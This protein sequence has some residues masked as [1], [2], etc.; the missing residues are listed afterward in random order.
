MRKA[1]TKRTLDA[2]KP[3]PADLFVW[4]TEFKGFGCKV[5]PKGKR[6]FILQYQAPGLHRTT[7]RYTLGTYGPMTVDQA[8]KTARAL[9]AQVDTG[10]DPALSK[11]ED[12]R[13]TK[14]DTVD[15]L[16][17]AYIENIRDRLKPRTLELYESLAKLYIRPKLG[18]MPVASITKEDVRRLHSEIAS[19][20]PVTANRVVRLVR[21][22]YS[23]L[24]DNDLFDRANPARKADR[25]KEKS[26][27]RFLTVEEL[28]RL[29]ETLRVAEIVGLPPAPLHTK[30]PSTKRKRN[31]GMFKSELK[32]ANPVAVSVLRFLL[33][34]GWREQEALTLKWSAVDL[35]NGRITLDDTKT[36]KTAHI[37]SAAALELLA[38]QP[39]VKDSPYVFP[40]RNPMHPLRETQRLWYAARHAAKLDDLRLHD[41]RHS[42]AS[43][44]ASHGY[45]LFLI[46]KFLGHKTAR[47][48]ER[49]AHL[50]DDVRK[51]M[52]D[53][54]G[55]TIKEALDRAMAPAA[56]IRAVS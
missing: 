26:R 46:G 6:V 12:R 13:A 53:Q 37:I 5:T 9:K 49:Y 42:A 43:V 44:A 38:A 14:E 32:P 4:D 54:V 35:R 21:S 23:Y 29:G 8:R 41:L 22:F 39:R 31:P 33:L 10:A 40:G 45:S 15:R 19:N 17:S 3:E 51:V 50:A 56:P 47:S 55:N 16:F 27:E 28:A 34:T 11:A 7:R 36:G 25:V 2:V 48:T 52:A 18:S 30:P 1:I 24:I 20:T